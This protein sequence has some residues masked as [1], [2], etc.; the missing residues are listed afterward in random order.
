MVKFPI[1]IDCTALRGCS[2]DQQRLQDTGS[3][4]CLHSM[5]MPSEIQSSASG[6]TPDPLKLHPLN[7][8]FVNIQFTN[9]YEV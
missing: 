7:I 5:L 4:G 2:W 8:Y 9:L 3:T 1:D 6:N